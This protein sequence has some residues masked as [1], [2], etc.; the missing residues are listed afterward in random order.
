VNSEPKAKSMGLFRFDERHDSHGG[1]KASASEN[2]AASLS[3]GKNPFAWLLP[4]GR[5]APVV[6]FDAIFARKAAPGGVEATDAE[7]LSTNSTLAALGARIEATDVGQVTRRKSSSSAPVHQE[8]EGT[9]YV[10]IVAAHGLRGS[11]TEMDPYVVV[12]AGAQEWQTPAVANNSDPQ[13]SSDNEFTFGLD[14]TVE[15][16][17]LEV[18]NASASKQLGK[19]VLSLPDLCTGVVHRRRLPLEGAG[20]I[21]GE[22]SVQVRCD[23]AQLLKPE[24]EQATAKAATSLRY[25]VT[26]ERVPYEA[27]VPEV[28]GLQLALPQDWED[29][30]SDEEPIHWEQVIRARPQQTFAAPADLFGDL[31]LEVEDPILGLAQRLQRQSES[32]KQ[33]PHPRK[34]FELASLREEMHVTTAA[35]AP[36]Q[37]L[38]ADEAMSKAQEAAMQKAVA[39]EKATERM[40]QDELQR[41]LRKMK[42][43]EATE[44]A[45]AAAAAEAESKQKDL[46]QSES[47]LPPE[48][49]EATAM[50]PRQGLPPPV[51]NPLAKPEPKPPTPAAPPVAPPAA[52]TVA[53]APAP[54]PAEVT[55]VLPPVPPKAV[56][57]VQQAKA[58]PAG[59]DNPQ[60]R[61]AVALAKV[62]KV[63]SDLNDFKKDASSKD[64]R[65]EVKKL[66]NTKVGQISATWSRIQEC[67][68]T[69]CSLL[70]KHTQDSEIRKVYVDYAMASRLADDAEVSVRSQP[71][72][73]W[74]IAEVSCRIFD[75]SPAVQELFIGLMCRNCP[76][77]RADF[78]AEGQRD[79]AASKRPQE[80]FSEM[81]DR[82]VSY[83]RLWIVIFITQGELGVIW[84]W[85]ARTLNHSP[86]TAAVAM[87]HGTLDMVGS[88]LQNRYQKQFMKLIA[89]IDG[90]YM[91]EVTT[92]QSNVKGEEADRLR[93][94]HNRLSR[95]LQDFKLRGRAMPP[96]GRQI[97]RQESELNP[98]I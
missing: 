13:W 55:S 8:V 46:L 77:L 67:T 20:E 21:C 6:G 65:M 19:A 32:S 36:N 18:I 86:S 47:K 62:A 49:A 15:L 26:P 17:E 57:P 39:K 70:S 33:A 12:R 23:A 27:N 22:L 30:E 87:I 45:Q 43:I 5:R 92:L 31:R 37:S 7:D 56:T 76:H 96:E 82:L 72:A 93:A 85:L 64:F 61:F 25:F 98:N 94:S 73:A 3:R 2:L 44:A 80:G 84:N 34:Y 75:K 9:V 59:W 78:S 54:A 97:A 68:S 42:E 50:G 83:Q 4:L 24:Q 71:R 35:E 95:W 41:F 16:L 1:L 63:E 74:S 38:E 51:P 89:Y 69:L 40:A 28:Q 14:P 90:R 10:C 58:Q 52:P 91:A 81:V 60:D 66:I 29:E 48:P 88:D 11:S 79:L 53:T